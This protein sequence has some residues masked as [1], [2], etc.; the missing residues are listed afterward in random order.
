MA[1]LHSN[2]ITGV[3]SFT[4]NDTAVTK[5]YVD[6]ILQSPSG[7]SGK[8]LGVSVYNL[9]EN[10]TIRTS[11]AGAN[12]ISGIVYADNYYVCTSSSGYLAASTDTIHWALRTTGQISAG[13]NVIYNDG[14][15]LASYNTAIIASTDTITWMARTVGSTYSINKIKYLN[16]LYHAGLNNR[17]YAVSTDTINWTLR[18]LGISASSNAHVNDMA[19]GNGMYVIATDYLSIAAS[20]DTIHWATRT[21]PY[22]TVSEVNS[23]WEGIG[24]LNDKFY[25]SGRVYFDYSHNRTATSTDSIHW[26]DFTE[27][28]INPSL[29]FDY[30]FN[31]KYLSDLGLYCADNNTG[32]IFSTDNIHW[33]Y[34]T[35]VSEGLFSSNTWDFI[36]H[37]GKFI[38]V[39]DGGRIAVSEERTK[40]WQDINSTQSLPD[41]NA[42]RGY[43]E[44]DDPDESIQFYVPDSASY[45]YVEAVGAGGGG[46]AG[47][48]YNNQP[49]AGRGGGAGAYAA[50]L[51]NVEDG[52]GDK[53]LTGS[54]GKGGSSGNHGISLSTDGIHWEVQLPYDTVGGETFWYGS[55][56]GQDASLNNVYFVAGGSGRIMSRIGDYPIWYMRTSGTSTTLLDAAY[57]NN[58]FVAS[59]SN[60]IFTST[61][62]IHWQQQIASNPSTIRTVKYFSD[63]NFY[64]GGDSGYFA[65]STDAVHWS[66]RTTSLSSTATY[67]ITYGGVGNYLVA[68]SSKMSYSTDTINWTL[69]T[70]GTGIPYS[71][72]FGNGVYV[73]GRNYGIIQSSTDTIHWV[74]RS[75]GLKYNASNDTV[76]RSII[77]NG[78]KFY[79]L[80]HDYPGYSEQ[81]THLI[82]STDAIN[83]EENV[84]AQSYL[85]RGGNNVKLSL[86]YDLVYLIS[87]DSERGRGT[88]GELSG[89]VFGGKSLYARGGEGLNYNDGGNNTYNPLFGYGGRDGGDP[90]TSFSGLKNGGD[91]PYLNDNIVLY[92]DTTPNFGISGGGAGAFGS[93]SGGDSAINI[94]GYDYVA[95]GGISTTTSLDGDNGVNSIISKTYGSGG[96]GGGAISVGKYSWYAVNVGYDRSGDHYYPSITTIPSGGLLLTGIYSGTGAGKVVASTDGIHWQ[97]RTTSLVSNPY[98]FSTALGNYFVCSSGYDLGVSTDTIHWELRTTSTSSV[99]RTALSYNSN[100]ST[101][102][103]GGS[104]GF[105]NTSTDNIHWTKRTSG[106]SS[107]IYDIT[108]GNNFFLAATN[109]ALHATI[110]STDGIH[111]IARTTGFT[112][113]SNAVSFTNSL[114]FVNNSSNHLSVS[115]DTVNWTLRTAVG[116]YSI[117]YSSTYGYYISSNVISTDAIHWENFYKQS[118]A[119]LNSSGT[120]SQVV[121][122]DTL[123]I[124][125]SG[126]DVYKPNFDTTE[127]AVG[128]GGKGTRGGGGGGGGFSIEGLK[129][130]VGAFGGDGFVRITWW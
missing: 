108:Y 32:H 76:P 119:S 65:V 62:T 109:D 104:G 125:G 42:I 54:V 38:S 12:S 51:V 56:S 26:V 106:T 86:S 71:S 40:R 115:T 83:W 107:Q 19:Y 39:G 13:Y 57:G 122:H 25:I 44:F 130:G 16:N 78:S 4:T 73:V 63:G 23:A 111:W 9:L 81:Q 58:T 123:G 30:S 70:A 68:G 55:A 43:Q 29:S 33:E 2:K 72:A 5:K 45:L 93:F 128:N 36:Y 117:V 90:G 98:K 92:S 31:F 37:D 129:A 46:N 10:W 75:S 53:I 77:F 6:N 3:T 20:T 15:Y 79:A 17:S 47:S 50:W 121:V 96:G 110:S 114:F 11:G 21:S 89:V 100:I 103:I 18:T 48:Y 67:T 8:F 88:D 102:A 69:R 118:R 84:E 85:G 124:W 66:L 127:S 64:A 14:Y 74:L 34:K 91:S 28:I 24:Y 99:I 112:T 105:I 94:Y 52:N 97:L 95:S 82:T 35:Y 120:V 87:G 22:Y 113:Y 80:Y 126:Y 60:G 7:Q 49:E 1:T 61:D 59:G 27:E 116:A 101:Y 41:G